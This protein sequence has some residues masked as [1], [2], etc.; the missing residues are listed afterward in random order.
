VGIDA[1]SILGIAQV[2][3]SLTGGIVDMMAKYNPRRS[4][5]VAEAEA[6]RVEEVGRATAD[7]QAYINMKL[8]DAQDYA[9]RLAEER[10]RDRLEWEERQA[11]RKAKLAEDV[12]ASRESLAL[13]R[14]PLALA[15]FQVARLTPDIAGDACCRSCAVGAPCESD[16]K[17]DR[18]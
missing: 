12:G 5:G 16:C 13:A 4:A 15:A 9:L 7:A 3:N 1:G 10:E 8:A 11:R 6:A 17:G 14:P 18:C 2:A